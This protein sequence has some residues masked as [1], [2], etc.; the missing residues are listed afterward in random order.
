V[1]RG[2]SAYLGATTI[3][4]VILVVIGVVALVRTILAGASGVAVGYVLGVG[5]IVAGVLRL[6]VL[7]RQR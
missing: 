2:R 1:S 3:F 6:I 7:R 5:L 4:S